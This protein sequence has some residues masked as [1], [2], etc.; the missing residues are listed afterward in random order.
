[1]NTFGNYLKITLFGASHEPFV[2]LTADGFS[3]GIALDLDLIKK[4]LQNRKG[5]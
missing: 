1:M 4:R 5:L 2:G 3:A